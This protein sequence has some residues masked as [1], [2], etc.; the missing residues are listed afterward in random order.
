M[1]KEILQKIQQA[2]MVLVGIGEE[3]NGYFSPEKKE[4]FQKA[5]EKLEAEG[6]LWMLPALYSLLNR[7]GE[8]NGEEKENSGLTK[9]SELLQEKNYFVIST[10]VNETIARIPWKKGR[11]VMPCGCGSKVQCSRGCPEV[12]ADLTEEGRQKI[13]NY[14]Q[15]L[16][17][18]PAFSGEAESIC[19]TLGICPECGAPL[20][21]NSI[22]AENY[23]EKGYLEEWEHYTKWLQGT[24]NKRLFILE[25]GVGMLFPSVIRWPFEKIAF[26]QKKAELCRINEKLYQ[27]S[28]ELK[29]KATGISKNAIDWL[30]LL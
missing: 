7:V 20:V 21:L 28:E 17:R 3:F 23:N 25:L 18:Y 24:L 2:D 19:E 30:S 1:E 27:L 10:S 16:L 22:Y 26:F 13:E 6:R 8:G 9:L 12:L 5:R 14:L 11:L 15:G 4:S 29:G